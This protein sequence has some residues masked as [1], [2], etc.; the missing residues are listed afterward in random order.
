MRTALISSCVVCLSCI[1]G[2]PSQA[3]VYVDSTS[4]LIDQDSSVE[5]GTYSYYTLRLKSGTSLAVDM[6]VQGGLTNSLTVWLLD[7]PN[8]QRFKGDQ[9]FSYFK[10]TSGRISSNASYHFTV[11]KPSVYYLIMDN[12]NAFLVSRSVHVTAYETINGETEA[13]RKIKDAFTKLYDGY[14]RGLF[15]FDG[16]DV[17]VTLCG[18]ENAFSTPNIIMCYELSDSLSKKGVPGA[19]VFVFLHEASHSLLNLWGFP[20]HDNEDVADELATFLLLFADQEDLAMQAADYWAQDVS[21]VEA[22]RKLYI[23]DR[24]AI[25]PQRARN[26]INWIGR[27]E[28]L[29]ARWARLLIP[30]FTDEILR[31]MAKNTSDPTAASLAARELASRE[32]ELQK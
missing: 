13:S 21:E 25:S 23:D 1:L 31:S 18:T 24:H 17:H 5:A 10:G 27:K 26:I 3:T 29:Q 19:T 4:L 28:D 12:R 15:I 7:L 6:T 11:P 2:T 14:L 16:F 22:L 8:F 9:E 32:S 20:L 30:R